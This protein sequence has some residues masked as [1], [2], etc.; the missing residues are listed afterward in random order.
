MVIENDDLCKEGFG[1][2]SGVLLAVRGNHTTLDV[3]DG[4]VLDIE[5]NIVSWDSN[6]NGSVMHFNRFYFSGHSSWRECE[7]HTSLD[8]SGLNTSHWNSS[9]TTN[10]VHILRGSRRGL[11]IG[12]SGCSML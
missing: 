3:L 5:S 11:S 4:N 9:N 8:G 10:L 1:F 6:F 7:S 2:L 12:R